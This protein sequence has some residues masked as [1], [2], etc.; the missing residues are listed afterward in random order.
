[1]PA[2][3]WP[4]G[5]LLGDA[6]REGG[7]GGGHRPPGEGGYN[8]DREDPVWPGDVMKGIANR[9]NALLGRKQMVRAPRPASHPLRGGPERPSA[10]FPGQPQQTSQIKPPKK[11]ESG[12]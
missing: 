2:L 12:S 3:P 10:R 4:Y 11:P 1:M 9:Q 6:T 5:M 8:S 7:G